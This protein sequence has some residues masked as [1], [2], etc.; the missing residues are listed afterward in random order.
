M[1]RAIYLSTPAVIFG[2][3]SVLSR[4]ATHM[5]RTGPYR[6]FRQFVMKHSSSA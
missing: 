5:D 2:G 6:G 1:L 4:R 3:S